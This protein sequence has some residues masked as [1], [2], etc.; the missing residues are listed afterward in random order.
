MGK[1]KEINFR[2]IFYAMLNR[3]WL[4]IIAAVVFGVAVYI[5]S[6]NF[7]TPRYRASV[8]MYVNNNNKEEVSEISS[9]DLAT[10]QRLVDTYIAILQQYS[11]AERVSERV[12]ESTG[13]RPS[14]QSILNNMAAAAINETEVFIITI[15]H[16]DPEMAMVIANCV[17]AEAEEFIGEIVTG[18][19]AKT[20]DHARKP[21]SPFAPNNFRNAI[22]GAFVGVALAVGYIAIWVITDVRIN[23]EEDLVMLSNA[24]VLGVIP[25]FDT[26]EKSSY[27]Y[28][29][30]PYTAKEVQ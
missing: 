23:G 17:A 7:I 10:S 22:L 1:S 6:S 29:K 9:S 11:F 24:P 20:V 2:E 4:V 3:I 15:N 13:K 18:S 27:G 28:Q 26:D 8:S 16:T 25:N 5:I 19:E 12:Y 30:K 14:P 21:K